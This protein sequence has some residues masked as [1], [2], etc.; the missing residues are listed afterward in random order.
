[1]HTIKKYALIILTTALFAFFIVWP[2]LPKPLVSW[3]G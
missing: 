2:Y 1:M 3:A